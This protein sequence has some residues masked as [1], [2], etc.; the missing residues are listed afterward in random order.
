MN[1]HEKYLA[2]KLPLHVT[3][4][5]KRTALPKSSIRPFFGTCWCLVSET[6]C[7]WGTIPT[8]AAARKSGGRT[9]ESGRYG[10]SSRSP[11][12][13]EHTVRRN[14]EA[15]TR[16]REEVIVRNTSLYNDGCSRHSQGDYLSEGRR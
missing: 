11:R 3:G 10:S 2:V 6:I 12:C 15:I 9:V 13:D 4:A 14:S 7:T 8:K 1:E 5:S 16:D